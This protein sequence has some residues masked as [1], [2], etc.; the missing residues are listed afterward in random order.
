M[1]VGHAYRAEADSAQGKQG[2]GIPTGQMRYEAMEISRDAEHPEE[3]KSVVPPRVWAET[4]QLGREG[5]PT[6]CQSPHPACCC[7]GIEGDM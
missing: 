5:R 6:H 4:A 7:Q 3:I 2:T 1:S